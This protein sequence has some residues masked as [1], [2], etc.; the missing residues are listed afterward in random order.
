MLPPTSPTTSTST[1]IA[2][3]FFDEPA[4]PRFTILKTRGVRQSFQRIT[5]T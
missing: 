1:C 5:P 3:V 2:P 4:P